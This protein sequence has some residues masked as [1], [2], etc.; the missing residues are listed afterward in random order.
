MRGLVL[1]RRP[2]IVEVIG[3]QRR[4]ECSPVDAV[5]RLGERDRGDHF[6]I[7]AEVADTVR[8]VGGW[9]A[10]LRIPCQHPA[11]TPG[12][13]CYGQGLDGPVGPSSGDASVF[14]YETLMA[15]HGRV[16]LVD[17]PVPVDTGTGISQVSR[18]APEGE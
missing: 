10:C 5:D 3:S 13:M 6:A 9:R 1:V 16:T 15:P 18:R 2:P 8:S 11:P 4:L 17:P 12:R 7:V 14:P